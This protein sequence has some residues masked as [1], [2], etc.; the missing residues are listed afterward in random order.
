[1]ISIDIDSGTLESHLAGS[2]GKASLHAVNQYLQLAQ[3]QQLN[4]SPILAELG[5]S[6]D[7]LGDSSQ[8]ITGDKFQALISAL[9]S[10]QTINSLVYIPLNLFNQAHIACLVIFL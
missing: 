6:A 2:L 4:I 5:I 1:M 10:F 3:A 7:F 8:Y 9:L